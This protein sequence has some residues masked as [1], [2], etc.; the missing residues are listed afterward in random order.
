MKRLMVGTGFAVLLLSAKS[1]AQSGAVSPQADGG[2][3][4]QTGC[5]ILKRMGRMDRSKSRLYSFGISGKQF[6]YVEGKL[7]EGVSFHGKM[8]DH[9]VRNLQARGAQVL[10]LDSH[11]TS[12]DLQEAR[13]NCQQ[14]TGKTPNH[15]EAKASPAAAAAP[16]GSAMSPASRPLAAKATTPKA[17]DSAS[18]PRAV[19]PASIPAPAMK[20]PTAKPPSAKVPTPK[21]EDSVSSAETTVAALLDVSSTPTGADIYIDEGFFGRTPATAII[22][23]PGDHKLVIKKSGFVDWKRKF[24]LL[25]GRSNVDASLVP[26]TK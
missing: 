22:L 12:E 20:P 10:V 6:R 5:V 11:Y 17:D 7:P 26:K 14:E 19:E 4:S 18:S 8:T 2:H 21:A 15:V 25:S 13:A 1:H 24:N 16:I 23:V 9:D 3:A